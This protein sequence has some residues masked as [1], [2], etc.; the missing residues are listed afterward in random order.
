M[1]K[2]VKGLVSIIVPT[3][4]EA[5]NLSVLLPSIVS[6]TY[7]KIEV[8]VN[9]DRGTVDATDK[10]IN[11]H[12]GRILIKH[13]Y[14]NSGMSY[15]RLMGAKEARGEYLLHLDADMKLSSRAVET[16]VALVGKR[17]GAIVIPEISYGE[18]YW[19]KVKAF[20]KS[21]Y[22]GDEMM[23]SARF[24]KTK[25]Y[26]DVG[27]HNVN[28]AL[29]EDKDLHLRI[30]NKGYKIKHIDDVIY[31]HEGSLN[32]WKDFKKKFYYG[33]TAHVFIKQ[34]PQHSLKQ[35]NLIFRPAYFRNWKKLVLNPAMTFSMVLMKIVE[36]LAAF[37]GVLSTKMTLPIPDPWR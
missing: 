32:L 12:K 33:R 8:I 34:H 17:Y 20:E 31:H 1:A 6:Q 28:M 13:I 3:K 14:K 10:V 2:V 4:N 11:K 21:L 9:D 26:W 5:V 25:V 37:L 29:S 18:G 16:C 24:I 27:G 7:K 15:G 19:A 30:K 22:V 23:S 36:A 35:A